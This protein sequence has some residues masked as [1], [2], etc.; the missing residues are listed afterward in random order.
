MGK[1]KIVKERPNYLKDKECKEIR[2]QTYESDSE[3]SDF[4][5]IPD[6]IEAPRAQ[7]IQPIARDRNQIEEA[8]DRVAEERQ[9]QE[10]RWRNL[11]R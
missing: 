5:L 7:A 9:A 2:R 3:L 6:E 11:G 4:D 8:Q 10:V 1:C